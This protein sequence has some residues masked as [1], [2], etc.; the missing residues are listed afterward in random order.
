MMQDRLLVESIRREEVPHPLTVAGFEV[1]RASIRPDGQHVESLVDAIVEED[2]EPHMQDKVIVVLI[3]LRAVAEEVEVDS[4]PLLC[5]RVDPLVDAEVRL[6]FVPAFRIRALPPAAGEPFGPPFSPRSATLCR[7][8]GAVGQSWPGMAQL[9]CIWRSANTSIHGSNG[10]PV[11]G[12]SSKTVPV[13]G[14][15]V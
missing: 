10:L 9:P 4:P 12:T 2:L 14:G 8:P 5:V 3:G 15:G 1:M 6:G 11:H 13:Q 7:L